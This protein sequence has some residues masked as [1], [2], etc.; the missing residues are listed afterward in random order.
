V[1]KSFNETLG[2]ERNGVCHIETEKLRT[3]VRNFSVSI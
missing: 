2:L 1:L 3:W